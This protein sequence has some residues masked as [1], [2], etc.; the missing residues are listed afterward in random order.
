MI[1]TGV[2]EKYRFD[3]WKFQILSSNYGN[4]WHNQGKHTFKKVYFPR[5][6]QIMRKMYWNFFIKH[7]NDMKSYINYKYIKILHHILFSLF[8]FFFWKT[9]NDN[10][11]R[12]RFSFSEPFSIGPLQGKFKCLTINKKWKWNPPWFLCYL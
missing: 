5:L 7:C 3:R 4:L 8:F 1:W 10:S 2:I 12:Y 9:R 11:S 6:T